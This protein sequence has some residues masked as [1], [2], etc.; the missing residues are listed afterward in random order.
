MC[1][2]ANQYFQSVIPSTARNLAKMN[3]PNLLQMINKYQIL[4]FLRM[5]N[6]YD[7]TW[8]S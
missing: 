1:A 4:R 7:A 5:T 8:A 3:R 6:G 2:K